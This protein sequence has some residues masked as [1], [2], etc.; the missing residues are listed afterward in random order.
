M[1]TTHTIDNTTLRALATCHTK[2]VLSSVLRLRSSHDEDRFALESGIALH[3]AWAVYFRGDQLADGSAASPE[4]VLLDGYDLGRPDD[5]H[6]S[7]AGYRVWSDAHIAPDVDWQA[8]FA[9]PNVLAVWKAWAVAHPRETLPFRVTDPRLIEVG[10]RVPLTADI[11]MGGRLDGFVV[12]R[13]GEWR[14][15]ENKS[16]GRLSEAYV[17]GYDLDS[18]ISLYLFAALHHVEGA[19]HVKGAFMNILELSK[20]PA[21]D[22]ACKT[23]GVAYKECSGLHL[24]SLF[25]LATRTPLQLEEWKGDALKLVAQLHTLIE[26]NPTIGRIGSV[27]Q[28]GKFTGS[29]RFCSFKKYC[30]AGRPS[31]AVGDFL[32]E[33]TWKPF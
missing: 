5:P 31:F 12:D 7:Y 11:E 10:F 14:L 32:V 23:H 33:D 24:K 20:L 28:Q 6:A 30:T 19:P 18:Q 2:A 1:G 8:R 13:E 16:T 21:S 17:A 9:W 26:D 29:C 4:T 22:R 25:Y 15:L 3:E 27:A